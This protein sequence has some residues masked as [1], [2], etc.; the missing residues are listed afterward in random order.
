MESFV[1]IKST[2][3]KQMPEFVQEDHP[4]FTTFVE[5]YYEFLEKRDG[6]LNFTRNAL[7]YVDPAETLEDFIAN[8]FEEMK[9]IPKI[10]SIFHA[11]EDNRNFTT[12]NLLNFVISDGPDMRLLAQHI[13][14]LYQAKGA[15]KSYKLLFRLLYNEDVEVYFPKVDMLKPS[16]GKWFR[17]VK[18]RTDLI[19]GNPFDVIGHIVKQVDPI[20]GRISASAKVENVLYI[21]TISRYDLVLAPITIDGNFV[22]D[23][24]ITNDSV[25]FMPEP[26]PKFVV[27]DGRGSG[28]KAG[29]KVIIYEGNDTEARVEEVRGG[30]ITDV[31]ILDG[32]IGHSVGEVFTIESDTGLGANIRVA[33]VD[34]GVITKV[35]IID[36]GQGYMT[37]PSITIGNGKFI[38]VGDSIGAV[39]KIRTLRPGYGHATPPE[40]SIDTNAIIGEV[41]LA[42][43][44]GEQISVEHF[45]LVTETETNLIQEDGSLLLDEY[46]E[47]DIPIDIRIFSVSENTARFSGVIDSIQINT[48]E[49]FHFKLEDNAG[50]ITTERSGN[51]ISR[52]TIKGTASGATTRVL[53]INPAIID[54]KITTVFETDNRFIN[55]DGKLSETTK[56]IQDSKYYQE[57][58]YVLRSA[59]STYEYRSAIRALLHPAGMAMFGTYLIGDKIKLIKKAI[60]GMATILTKILESKIEFDLAVSSEMELQITVRLQST[61]LHNY[62]WLEMNKFVFGPHAEGV[63][64]NHDHTAMKPAHAIQDLPTNVTLQIKDL[65]HIMFEDFYEYGSADVSGRYVDRNYWIEGYEQA[66]NLT[67]LDGYFERGYYEPGYYFDVYPEQPYRIRNKRTNITWDSEITFPDANAIIPSEYDLIAAETG[68]VLEEGST[69]FRKEIAVD[70]LLGTEDG[71]SFD[72][73]SAI[74]IISDTKYI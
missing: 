73:E 47:A 54:S 15:I 6:P 57:F 63:H 48:E 33:Q 29:N 13:Y 11:S 20:S 67:L 31:I 17:E 74:G 8:F 23:R 51:P 36:G 58:S 34:N 14:E 44:D 18:I 52:C 68:D 41:N 3:P 12:E 43:V 45:R 59:V 26:S 40:C 60:Y 49:D 22:Q 21:D 55:E 1:S 70:Y 32:G 72:S 2:I 42:F 24:I 38:A 25:S 56:R 66:G 46:Q 19:S 71:I 28:Y 27:T 65:G 64:G 61:L 4:L 50:F 39:N 35:A 69:M 7:N 62:R 10:G 37:Y 9:Q 16:D 53:F 30:P 5:A